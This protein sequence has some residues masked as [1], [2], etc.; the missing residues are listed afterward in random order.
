[1]STRTLPPINHSQSQQQHTLHQVLSTSTPGTPHQNNNNNNQQH[2]SSSSTTIRSVGGSS[3]LPG[4]RAATTRRL[5]ESV[6]DIPPHPNEKQRV[7][8]ERNRE[9]ADANAANSFFR[10]H[11]VKG[12]P[13]KDSPNTVRILHSD[14][15]RGAW[16]LVE[17]GLLPSNFDMGLVIDGPKRGGMQG[18]PFS[19]APANIHKHDEQ[20]VRKDIQSGTTGGGGGGNSAGFTN[21]KYDTRDLA[22]LPHDRSQFMEAVR[23]KR[24]LLAME[25]TPAMKAA[26]ALATRKLDRDQLH[27]IHQTPASKKKQE[28]EEFNDEKARIQREMELAAKDREDTRTYGELL[29]KFSLHEFIIRKGVTLRNTPEFNSFHRS[30]V[31]KWS[32]INDVI[33][34]LE[35]ML[36]ETAVPVAYIDGKRIIELATVDNGMCT[37]DQLLSCLSNREEVE[38]LVTSLSHK[39]L[40]A[41]K[42]FDLAATIIQ[43][44][45]RG[46]R[47]HK[48]YKLLHAANAAAVKIQHQYAV[49]REHKATQRKIRLARNELLENWEKLME[50]FNKD[51]PLVSR[52]SGRVLIHIPS[53]SVGSDHKV[54]VFAEYF[55]RQVLPRLAHL[56]DPNIDSIVMVLPAKPED[57]TLN[58]FLATLNGAGIE[59]ATPSRVSILV[60]ELVA[61]SSSQ[62]AGM[63]KRSRVTLPSLTLSK[64]IL[65]SSRLMRLLAAHV[66]GKTAYMLCDVVT[67]DEQLLAAKIGVPILGCSKPFDSMLY[68]TKSGGRQLLANADVSIPIGAV[69][70]RSQDELFLALSKLIVENPTVLRW[71]IKLDA[72]MQGRG[73]AVLDTKRIRSYDDVLKLFNLGSTTNSN[74]NNNNNNN[75]NSNSPLTLNSNN[76]N[77]ET[78]TV[79]SAT[80]VAA[81]IYGELK[82]VAARRIKI[83]LSAAY[84]DWAAFANAMKKM[85]CVVEA[86]PNDIV[87]SPVA[88]LFIPPNKT[89]EPQVL[90][91]QQQI[92]SPLTFVS[93]GVVYPQTCVPD[94]AVIDASKNIGE[95]LRKH[96]VVGYVSVDFVCFRKDNSRKLRMWA[97]GV[98]PCLTVNSTIHE[99]ACVLRHEQLGGV[100]DVSFRSSIRPPF[101]YSY[102][103]VIYHPHISALRHAT[104]FQIAR[105]RGLSFEPESTKE[106]AD[107][108]AVAAANGEIIM[109][110]TVFH[111]IDTLLCGA[112]GALFLGPTPQKCAQLFAVFTE[113]LHQTLSAENALLDDPRGNLLHLLAASRTF[114]AMYTNHNNN[115]NQDGNHNKNNTATIKNGTTKR[116]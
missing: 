14:I 95:V 84:P 68:S 51:W 79:G 21:I 15:E 20:F 109:G 57:E 25:P 38:P 63:P 104:F 76:N 52:T 114:T 58:Y 45:F 98:R 101:C 39:F 82:E 54:P 108:C 73:I 32:A 33:L 116:K 4:K 60:P 66:R 46:H 23:A 8:M 102:T 9:V 34:H 90:G 94:E 115:N 78:P 35:R 49:H 99:F 53:V 69:G 26:A 56:A 41:P 93:L 29:D 31:Q 3:S 30:N 80:A 55:Q 61:S 106:F 113:L 110:G 97:V 85:S 96:N 83:S 89:S 77:N 65:C 48:R 92:V 19:C 64:L 2:F 86:A 36:F 5:G 107:M 27:K 62:A 16:S 111:L 13:T 112:V 103:G 75:G 11:T 105:Q 100:S 43:A 28:I 88:H 40:F 70:I 50:R 87:G 72:E 59:R 91:I 12:K 22:N 10:A 6:A 42:R 44:A 17:R 24:A 67:E 7:Q 1:M 74:I 47:Q 37:R 18:S 81:K 71:I